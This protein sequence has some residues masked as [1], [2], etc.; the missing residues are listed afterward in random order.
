MCQRIAV[1]D[2]GRI[3][4]MDTPEGLKQHVRDLSVIELETLGAPPS[5]LDR[6][7]ALPFVDAVSVENHEQKQLLLIQSPRGSEAVPEVLPL[8]GGELLIGLIYILLGYSLFRWFE[9]QAK[10]RGTLEAF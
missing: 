3:I 8:L 6:L 2:H 7:R 4:A 9:F 1:I 10:R 5:V